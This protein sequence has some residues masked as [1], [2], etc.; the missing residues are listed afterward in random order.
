MV[1]FIEELTIHCLHMGPNAK[2]QICWEKSVMIWDRK[3]SD[4]F[5]TN[6]IHRIHFFSKITR[7]TEWVIELID[8]SI[9]LKWILFN[10]NEITVVRKSMC[11]TQLTGNSVEKKK[12]FF[13]I[14][15]FIETKMHKEQTNNAFHAMR[16]QHIIKDTQWLDSVWLF[17]CFD[18]S[19]WRLL[20]ISIAF[21]HLERYILLFVD[22]VVGCDFVKNKTNKHWIRK[23]KNAAI[24][25][26]QRTSRECDEL[27]L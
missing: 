10:E 7:F 6:K 20:L 18:R 21:I 14:E 1:L 11:H 5:Q 16:S 3:C 24:K 25:F 13:F 8:M 19:S 12:P 23:A 2:C 9:S 4:R 22:V 17:W 15:A 27:Y 26:N